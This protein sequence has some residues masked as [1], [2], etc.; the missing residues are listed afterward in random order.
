MP[1]SFQLSKRYQQMILFIR[2]KIHPNRL[3]YRIFSGDNL[4]QVETID[5]GDVAK[6]RQ[7]LI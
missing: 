5:V 1:K 4:G 7:K 2:L 3:Y 6:W